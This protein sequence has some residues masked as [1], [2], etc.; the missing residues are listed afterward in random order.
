MR[1]KLR[2]RPQTPC[3]ITLPDLPLPLPPRLGR[4]VVTYS[5]SRPLSRRLVGRA[6]AVMARRL[7]NDRKANIPV[8]ALRSGVP[9]VDLEPDVRAQRGGVPQYP[10]RRA[11]SDAAPLMVGED[12]QA[13]NEHSVGSVLLIGPVRRMG[14]RWPRA[15][16][17]RSTITAW[18]VRKRPQPDTAAGG[19]TRP[20]WWLGRGGAG[21]SA[22]QRHG[23]SPV[24]VASATMR[25]ARSPSSSVSRLM[26]SP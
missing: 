12:F 16:Q 3:S 21:G 5:C 4:S 15:A 13:V 9:L 23:H 20:G 19:P 8:E 2:P 17:S 18:V 24:G 25:T 26:P 11:C 7:S 22:R 10:F 1:P 14:V 6:H